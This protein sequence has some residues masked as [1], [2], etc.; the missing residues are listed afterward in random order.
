MDKRISGISVAIATFNEE[1]NLDACLSAITGW[2]HE[3]V[4][5]DGGSSDQTV[6]IARKFHA[7]IIETDNPGIFHIN[8]Q[9]AIEACTYPWILQLDADEVVDTD[10][11]KEIKET[12][13]DQ[14]AKDGYSIPRKNYFLGH[15]L[16]KGGQYPDFVIRL[17][18][19]GKGVF[20]AKSV[21]EQITITGSVGRLVHPLI[22]N[23]N[24]TLSDYWRKSDAYT[25]LTAKEMQQNRLR[26]NIWNFFLY[27]I[28]KPIETFFLLFIRHKG[29]FDGYRG[30]LFALFSGFHHAIAYW[31]YLR[32]P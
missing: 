9:K 22:H 5:V 32:L 26:K 21:H 30:F 8:K 10:L 16:K 19:N 13:L 24:P 18:R 14:N 2:T 17:F 3:I 7:R 27:E 23:T 11:Q 20:P 28:Y 29:F 4:L 31:K 25:S 1:K 12:I 15:F 6:E